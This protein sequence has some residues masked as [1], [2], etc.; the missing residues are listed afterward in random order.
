MLTLLTTTRKIKFFVPQPLELKEKVC[1]V[2]L[3]TRLKDPIIRS[4]YASLV[5][6]DKTC[7]PH[8]KLFVLKQ[9]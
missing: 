8:P 4:A 2:L 5:T 6:D 9:D 1:E 3:S 7:V